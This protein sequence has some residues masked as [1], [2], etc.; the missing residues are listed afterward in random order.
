[1]TNKG[2]HGDV[3]GRRSDFFDL[4][5]STSPVGPKVTDQS[6]RGYQTTRQKQKGFLRIFF[7]GRFIS[8]LFRRMF[9]G[10]FSSFFVL[11]RVPCCCCCF[12]TIVW[13]APTN[14]QSSSFRV[15]PLAA[16]T[17]GPITFEGWREQA[18]NR[19]GYGVLFF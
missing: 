15:D 5:I 1:M 3:C 2:D 4:Q 8:L 17:E 18:L 9:S 12:Y 14:N 16:V 10:L 11:Q 13:V 6:D 19:I 7:F